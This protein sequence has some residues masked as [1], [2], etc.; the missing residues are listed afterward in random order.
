MSNLSNTTPGLVCAHHHLYSSL[1]RGMPAPPRTPAGFTDILE[2][3]WWRLDRAL[4]LEGI[5]WSAMLGA[6]EALERGC[7]A[8]IDHHESPEAIEGSLDVIAEACAEVGVRVD[9]AYGVTDRHGPEGARRGLAE[10]ERYLRAGGRGR[11]GVHA[12][13]TCTDET[14]E[15]AAG[16]AAEL[17]VGVHIHVAEGETD[18]GAADRLRNLTADDWLLVHGVHLADDHGLTGTI[19]H[20]PRSNMNN[21][22]GY[23][24][25]ARFT[26]PVALG[27]DGI[28]ADM[29]D[30][31]R[32]AYVRHREDDVTASPEAAW[33]YLA[34]GWDLF[35]EA[36]G[37]QV[38]WSHD[39]MDPWHLA[40]SPG[41]SPLQVEVDGRVVWADGSATRVDADEIRARAAEEAVRLHARLEEM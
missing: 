17:G 25:P 27:S 33:S 22:V 12:A 29:L 19:V 30:E 11:V 9:C 37:D 3:V 34:T 40:F 36:L 13:F 2:L 5:R 28:G 15:S 14:L 21:S 7:T 32:V 41:V 18:A 23:S 26:N 10:N 16:L 35:P 24:R 4:D 31:F 20:N 39:P 38:T 8:V 1:A 6:L